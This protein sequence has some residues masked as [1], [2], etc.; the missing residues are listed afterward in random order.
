MGFWKKPLIGFYGLILIAVF[1]SAFFHPEFFRIHDY[2]H[3]ARIVEMRRSLDAGHVPVHWTQNFGYGYG[4]PLFLFYGPFAFYIAVILTYFGLSAF[5]AMQLLFFLCGVVGFVGMYR[6]LQR[7]GHT[8]AMVGS[9][10]LLAAPYRAVDLFVRG[11]LNEAWA[12]SILPWILWAQWHI[13]NRPARGAL[14]TAFW[15]A[16]LIMTHNLTAFIALP[17][18]AVLGTIG[19]V[20]FV[21]RKAWIQTVLWQIGGLVGGLLLSA[22]YIIPAFVEKEFTIIDTILGGYFDYHHHFLYI[23][24]FFLVNWGYGGS[25]F[26]P[27]DGISFH[28]GSITWA[29]LLLAGLLL[30]RRLRETWIHANNK[31]TSFWQRLTNLIF[32]L[33]AKGWI[34]V[35]TFLGIVLSL[36]LTTFKSEIVWDTI[37]L[38][39]F[40]QFPWRYLSIAIV[41][42]SLASALAV[43]MVRHQALR[44]LLVVIV[45]CVALFAQ[46]SF[47]QPEKFLDDKNDFYYT[48]SDLIRRQMSSILPDF[49]PLDL[50]RDLP[51]VAP[52][53][54]IVF[55]P[56]LETGGDEINLPHKLLWQGSIPANTTIIWNVAHFPGWKYYVGEQLVEPELRADGRMT[57][58]T[59]ETVSSVGALFTPTPIRSATQILSGLTFVVW[60]AFLIRTKKDSQ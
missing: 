46:S 56:A 42:T 5:T 43:S 30:L 2:T 22:W 36:Y 23:R 39:S 32:E 37:P 45:M 35:G 29:L 31:H 28:L 38:F 60:L 59:N 1:S 33:R 13:A 10:L 4:M 49:I 19:L 11:A 3:V 54:R 8:A 21:P 57:Y 51:P 20:T 53:N 27:N 6:L 16:A 15:V 18:L 47:H 52:E 41:L 7:W 55:A 50:D 12:I 17:F 25:E 14:W 9:T 44:V 26:G 40:V 48:D 58:V 34:L 24:Q